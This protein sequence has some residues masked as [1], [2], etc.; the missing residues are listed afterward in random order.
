MDM[1]N[2]NIEHPMLIESRKHVAATLL[3]FPRR[4]RCLAVSASLFFF[5]IFSL[6][7]KREIKLKRDKQGHSTGVV[8]RWLE[9]RLVRDIWEGCR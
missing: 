8:S 3:V 5:Q 7:P 1:T 9:G 4:S 6:L 2:R